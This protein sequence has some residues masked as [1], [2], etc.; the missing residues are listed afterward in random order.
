EDFSWN[1]NAN[2]T[3]INNEILNLA[4]TDTISSGLGGTV[5][6]G[7]GS[8]L[9]IEG[10][11][12]GHFFGLQQ[13]GLYD[14]TETLTFNGS[15][16]QAGDIKFVDTNG[17]GNINVDDRVFLGYGIADKFWGLTNTFRYKGLSLNVF[18]QG[19][20]GNKIANYTKYNLNNASRNTN[21]TVELLDRWTPTN[22]DTNI[23]RA[24]LTQD[25]VF[26]DAI[27]EDGD[28]VRLKT[29][30]LGYNFTQNV[31]D[32]LGGIST[33]N[34]YATGTNLLTWTKYTG[35]DPDITASAGALNQGYDNGGFPAT[36]SIVV[37][38]NI[39]F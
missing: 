7:A 3:H 23:P 17:D 21:G 11:Q 16:K 28:Y 8:Q 31:L 22:T 33:L 13:D 32:K 34:I 38:L 30:T 19:S 39:G 27:L 12:L 26:S 5:G 25:Y 2:F 6:F 36:K 35:L 18:L 10:D 37:G 1:V 20:H 24:S 9:L 4:E 15:T 14:G 29:I